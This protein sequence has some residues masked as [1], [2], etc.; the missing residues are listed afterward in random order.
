M[1]CRRWWIR[2]LLIF[3]RC[4]GGGFS[5]TCYSYSSSIELARMIKIPNPHCMHVYFIPFGIPLK[6]SQNQKQKNKKT[7]YQQE[8][9]G[10]SFTFQRPNLPKNP[11]PPMQAKQTVQLCLC[12]PLSSI[13]KEPSLPSLHISRTHPSLLTHKKAGWQSSICLTNWATTPNSADNSPTPT[14]PRPSAHP[15]S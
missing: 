15:A 2:V 13:P 8:K 9:R 6:Y 12:P 10:V 1:F 3:R 11:S 5:F 7:V 4:G 14:A